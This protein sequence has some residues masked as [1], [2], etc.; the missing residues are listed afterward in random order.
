MSVFV[1]SYVIVHVC[2]RT[3]LHMYV[4]AYVREYVDVLA[5]LC[6][7]V[8]RYVCMYVYVHICMCVCLICVYVRTPCIFK[9]RDFHTNLDVFKISYT[10]SRHRWSIKSYQFSAIYKIIGKTK[11]FKNQITKIK[12]DMKSSKFYYKNIQKI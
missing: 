8:H 12:L 9:F 3:V 4:Y 11:L 7:H 5:C 1:Y 6:K 2:P 10:S